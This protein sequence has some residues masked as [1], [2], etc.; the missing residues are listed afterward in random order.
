LFLRAK[1][2]LVTHGLSDIGRLR[3]SSRKYV[4][5]LWHGQGPKADGHA[6]KAFNAKMLR[7]LDKSM[8]NATAFLTCSRLDSYM[9][10]YALALKPT[11]ILP[12]GYPRCDYLLNQSL[13]SDIIPS[14]YSD[15]PQYDKVLLYAITWRKE[16]NALFFPFDDFTWKDLEYWCRD[17]KILLLIRPHVNVERDEEREIPESRYI[18]S[19]TFEMLNDIMYILPKV[20]LLITDYSSI[21]TDFLLLNRPIVYIPYDLDEF[22]KTEGFCYPEYDFWSPGEKVNTFASFKGAVERG[23]IGD[24]AFEDQ[25]LIVNKLVNEY[26]TP[27]ATE[28]VYRYLVKLLKI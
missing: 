6:S 17:Q 11:Q 22:R 23:L 2:L 12:L 9:R 14:L 25:R 28:R 3:P 8:E 15:L 20:D 27:G 16:G 7:K 1:T 24:D 21:Q 18:R 10:A 4:I 26:Q 13:W 19:L 5:Y